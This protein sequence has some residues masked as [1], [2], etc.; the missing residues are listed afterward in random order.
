M[1]AT[2]TA[3]RSRSTR[4]SAT[5]SIDPPDTNACEGW[6]LDA[7]GNILAE[8]EFTIEDPAPIKDFKPKASG[9]HYLRVSCTAEDDFGSSYEV[10]VTA[11]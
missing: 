7:K 8:A 1:S 9:K 6:L 10:L 11:R 3:S 5:P 2:M 4:P